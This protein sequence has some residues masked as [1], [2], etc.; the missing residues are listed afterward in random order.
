MLTLAADAWIVISQAEVVKL[1]ADAASI[2]TEEAVSRVIAPA[3][4]DPISI[5]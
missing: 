5:T 1:E 3:L 4:A 2:E